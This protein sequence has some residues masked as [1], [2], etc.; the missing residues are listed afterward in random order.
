[1]RV[2]ALLQTS[3]DWLPL[4]DGAI[5]ATLLLAIAAVTTTLLRHASA[6]ARHLVW[7][8]SL[9]GALLLPLA[10]MAIPQ[11]QVPLI[12]LSQPAS[13]RASRGPAGSAATSAAA[14]MRAR[15]GQSTR[16]T[17]PALR[18]SDGGASR[19]SG[20][21]S[22]TALFLGLWIAGA[23]AILARLAAGV[24][25]VHMMARRT[26]P[27]AD[28]PWLPLARALAADLRVGRIG[29]RRSSHES[30]GMPMAWGV[31]R[32]VVVMPAQ[33]DDW[34]QEKL[35]VVLLH[36]LAHVK[37]ADCLTHMLAQVACALYWMNPLAWMA[38]RRAR[39]ERERACDDLVLASGTAGADYAAQ[40]LQIA[41]DMRAGG[42]SS[43]I[44]AASL[45]MAHHTQLEGRL[46]AIL[47]PSVPRT[48]LS[49]VRTLA[50][51]AI[52][53]LTLVPLASVQP[54]TY[55]QAPGA[56]AI[57]PVSPASQQI[58][59]GPGQRYLAA[60]PISEAAKQR[61]AQAAIQSVI[62]EATH[63]VTEGAVRSVTEGVVQ[64][65]VEGIPN[66]VAGSIGSVFQANP[67]PRPMPRN[68]RREREQPEVDEEQRAK[69]DP[70]VVAA[71]TEALKDAD[72]DV[73]QAAM[74]ALVQMR[75][76]GVYE[77]LVQALRDASADV[78]ESAAFGLGQLD[79]KRAVAPLTAALK[80]SASGVREQAAFALGQIGDS[81]AVEG[82]IGVLKDPQANVREQA[83][84]ALGQIG[85]PRA[86]D[87]L[88]AAL[89]DTSSQVRRQA[90]F[91]IGQLAR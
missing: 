41:R 13:S 78:R 4:I 74:H 65:I 70:K 20:N 43:T 56:D 73:R 23:L 52:A 8:S 85:D 69:A 27:A 3:V 47:D 48:G 42:F 11:W 51:S 60:S 37:R 81:A 44:A 46:M 33:A 1:M 38:A 12:T 22:W 75:D 82:L 87:G 5:K 63:G 39:A 72:K 58:E 35:R 54:W 31:V 15:L 6:A 17:A 86:I 14:E 34:P 7:T 16:T 40:L 30:M 57:A 79:D 59:G 68:H 21:G 53:L 89:K 66:A 24:A 77:P 80:D 32:P 9:I 36:E 2:D 18:S 26:Q 88:S 10:S 84:F 76:P 90:A 28:A 49:R 61:L 29:F 25:A 83:A 55:A 19:W 62:Q 50:G 64:G 91:A 67:N 71:L 45:A